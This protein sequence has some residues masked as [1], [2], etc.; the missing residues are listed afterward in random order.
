MD[1]EEV[2]SRLSD[3]ATHLRWVADET[4]ADF[5]EAAASGRRD[6]DAVDLAIDA[7]LGVNAT[8]TGDAG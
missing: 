1:R 6:A 7:I 5:P 2:V 4:E 3:L 8:D